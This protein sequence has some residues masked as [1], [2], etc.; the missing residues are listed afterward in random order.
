MGKEKLVEFILLFAHTF[1]LIF[2]NLCFANYN[3]DLFCFSYKP[4]KP[5]NVMLNQIIQDESYLMC[6]VNVKYW[7]WLSKQN[8]FRKGGA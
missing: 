4:Y 8:A 7:H 6:D 2:F 3:F 1:L 5:V